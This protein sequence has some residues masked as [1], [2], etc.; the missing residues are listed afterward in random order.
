MDL[1]FSILV[2]FSEAERDQ[3]F[4]VFFPAWLLFEWRSPFRTQLDGR[5]I[6][7][8]ARPMSEVI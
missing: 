6:Y 1:F 7:M 8:H 3:V 4:S 2:A 5:V